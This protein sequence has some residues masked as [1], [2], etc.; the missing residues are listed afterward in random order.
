MFRAAAYNLLLLPVAVCTLCCCGLSTGGR[1]PPLLT[2]LCWLDTL[3]PRVFLHRLAT[4]RLR[5][6]CTLAAFVGFQKTQLST[7]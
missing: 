4:R 3:S 1:W 5:F 6:G 2:R 7:G